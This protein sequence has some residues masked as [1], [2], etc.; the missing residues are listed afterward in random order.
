MSIA[1]SIARIGPSV[2]AALGQSPAAVAAK[3]PE[4]LHGMRINEGRTHLQGTKIHGPGDVVEVPELVARQLFAD[5]VAVAVNPT[6][7]TPLLSLPPDPEL[8]RPDY[9][10]NVPWLKVKVIGKSWYSA[11]EGRTY[12]AGDELE[13]PEHRAVEGVFYGALK[14]ASKNDGFTIR[15][16]QYLESLTKG[17]AAD[18]SKNYFRNM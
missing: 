2:A 7:F 11:W 13:A 3:A 16:K 1:N 10:P 12:S 5:K 9:G 15:G 8:K 14:L 18:A 4:K 6:E 17:R